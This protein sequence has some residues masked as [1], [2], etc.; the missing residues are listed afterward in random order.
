MQQEQKQVIPLFNSA[1]N[2]ILLFSSSFHL[3][4]CLSE[5]MVVFLNKTVMSHIIIN[6]LI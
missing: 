6:L 4:S 1:F 5:Q 2:P 3:D